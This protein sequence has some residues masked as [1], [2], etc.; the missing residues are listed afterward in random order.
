MR[1]PNAE[2]GR[3]TDMDPFDERPIPERLDER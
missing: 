3:R 2:L 1:L